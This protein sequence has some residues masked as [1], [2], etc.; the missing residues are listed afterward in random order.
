MDYIALGRR[1]RQH[2]KEQRMTQVELAHK[3]GLSVSFLGH[4]ERGTRKASLETLVSIANTLNI[5]VDELLSESLRIEDPVQKQ[6]LEGK[7]KQLMQNLV[8]SIT[9]NW[10]DW[11]Q[12]EEDAPSAPSK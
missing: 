11:L 3:M 1:V 5:S 7:Q 8:R 10:D 9:E 12:D 6:L 2:R 4:I